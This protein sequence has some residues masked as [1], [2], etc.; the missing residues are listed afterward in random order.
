MN[1]DECSLTQITHSTPTAPFRHPVTRSEPPPLGL[2]I[3]SL[4]FAGATPR[5]RRD[6]HV[7][8]NVKRLPVTSV[9]V[10]G[11]SNTIGWR[12]VMS[13]LTVTARN[14]SKSFRA[15]HLTLAHLAH[16]TA[17]WLAPVKAETEM[18]NFISLGVLGISTLKYSL[19]EGINDV[20]MEGGQEYG[21]TNIISRNTEWISL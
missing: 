19:E 10:V 13:P 17:G 9:V 15:F 6:E 1:V 14:L 4:Y 5:R 18:H 8:I 2:L 20:K 12:S 16:R 11:E 21:V 7:A 3:S